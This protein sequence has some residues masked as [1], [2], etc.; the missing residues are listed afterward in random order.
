MCDVLDTL[1]ATNMIH[2]TMDIPLVLPLSEVM[3]RFG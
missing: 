2:A 3:M 1:H